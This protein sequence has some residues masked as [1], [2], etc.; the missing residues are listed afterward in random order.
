MRKRLNGRRGY[1]HSSKCPIAACAGC[2]YR[3]GVA[4]QCWDGGAHESARFDGADSARTVR[5]GVFIYLSSCSV[6]FPR[7]FRIFEQRRQELLRNGKTCCIVGA[8]HDAPYAGQTI[9]SRRL[10]CKGSITVVVLFLNVSHSKLWPK[11]LGAQTLSFVTSGTHFHVGMWWH[12][13]PQ[14]A[15]QGRSPPEREVKLGRQKKGARV[16]SQRLSMNFVQGCVRKWTS[17]GCNRSWRWAEKGI[18]RELHYVLQE[19]YETLEIRLVVEKTAR[20]GR[21]VC[22]CRS[23]TAVSIFSRRGDRLSFDLDQETSM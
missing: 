14:K 12:S 15:G 8:Q 4:P 5:K 1:R 21:A 3:S 17:R 10:Y 11:S 2:G 19:R 16:A 9:L 6:F 7:E 23:S 20:Q 13:R 18:R 22:R